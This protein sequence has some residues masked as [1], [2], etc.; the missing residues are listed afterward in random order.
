MQK[1]MRD[2]VAAAHAASG[3]TMSTAQLVT[4]ARNLARHVEEQHRAL[5]EHRGAI[6]AI[7]DNGVEI[8]ERL[9]ER[10]PL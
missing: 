5:V 9:D 1:Q 10:W 3:D 8:A 7:H 6:V 2:D 4:L